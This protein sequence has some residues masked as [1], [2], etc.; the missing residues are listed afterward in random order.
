M[1][2]ELKNSL[3]L[4]RFQDNISQTENNIFFLNKVVLSQLARDEDKLHYRTRDV[5]DLSRA[6]NRTVRSRACSAKA[7]SA[8]VLTGM[9]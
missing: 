2:Y 4:H 5:V 1:W 8:S 3:F 9:V 6:A 7:A